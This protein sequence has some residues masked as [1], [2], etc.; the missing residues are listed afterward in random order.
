MTKIVVNP[1]QIVF[2]I[3]KVKSQNVI[4]N[5]NILLCRQTRKKVPTSIRVFYL[6]KTNTEQKQKN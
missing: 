4:A 1:I 5:K 2:K 3:W 6:E